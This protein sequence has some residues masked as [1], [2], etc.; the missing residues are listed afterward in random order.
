[1][2]SCERS[3]VTVERWTAFVITWVVVSGTPGPN[4][5]FSIAVGLDNPLPRAFL[6]PLGIGVAALVHVVIASLG[7]STLLTAWP[8]LFPFV[9][10]LGVAYLLWL[11][12]RQ[13]RTRPGA[14]SARHSESGRAVLRRGVLVSLANPKAI[15]AY[16]AVLPHFISPRSPLS[17]QFALLGITASVV[18]TSVYCVYAA[19]ASAFS[20]AVLTASSSRTVSHIAGGAYFVAA[21]ALAAVSQ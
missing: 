8:Q 14:H 12:I 16:A 15:V 10:W 11:A 2:G 1:M 5:A 9:K 18:A 6:A 19:L 13:W 7:I 17:P 21:T 4:A 20:R 3:V